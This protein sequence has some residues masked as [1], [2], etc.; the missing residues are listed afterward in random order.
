MSGGWLLKAV[1]ADAPSFWIPQAPIL[2]T[3]DDRGHITA[4]RPAS[5][6]GLRASTNE[7]AVELQ[8]PAN[9]CLD[10]HAGAL[11]PVNRIFLTPCNARSISKKNTISCGG[12]RSISASCGCLPYLLHGH[13]YTNDFIWPRKWKFCSEIDAYGLYLALHGVELATRKKFYGLLKRQI[14]VFRH[15]SSG[16]RRGWYQGEWTDLMESH[17]RLHNS[18]ML[19]LEAGLEQEAEETIRRALESRR[20]P[21]LLLGQDGY[22]AVVPA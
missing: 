15:C 12:R 18:A 5:V 7:M 13:V 4:E 8:L 2:R 9:W 21:G 10:W 3:L 1:D 14:S 22:R 17:Y 20:L 6:A 19:M 11:N 16:A